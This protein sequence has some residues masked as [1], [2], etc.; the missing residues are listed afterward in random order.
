MPIL[1]RVITIDELVDVVRRTVQV[2]R[3]HAV[4]L[5][6]CDRPA[7][8][9]EAAKAA[10]ALEYTV[11]MLT[12]SELEAPLPRTS[13][14]ASLRIAGHVPTLSTVGWMVRRLIIGR[15]TMVR[16]LPCAEIAC[17]GVEIMAAKAWVESL[18]AGPSGK[19]GEWPTP[20]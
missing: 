16:V 2:H 6:T 13:F 15:S 12:R 9:D 17:K 5:R 10:D 19:S 18:D 4:L 3:R 11:A 14:L 20:G 1:A 7:E 8:A